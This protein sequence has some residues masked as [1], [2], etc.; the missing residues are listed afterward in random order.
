LAGDPESGQAGR[1]FRNIS[2]KIPPEQ[3]RKLIKA[4]GYAR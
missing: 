3:V 4:S 2:R 1:I